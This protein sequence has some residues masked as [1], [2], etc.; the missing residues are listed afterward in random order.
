MPFVEYDEIEAVC[1]ECG[2]IFRSEDALE[3]HKERTHAPAAV[4]PSRK[5]RGPER[6]SS[7][8]S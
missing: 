7:P 1:S 2:M 6:R 4:E 3:S 8:S 5:K